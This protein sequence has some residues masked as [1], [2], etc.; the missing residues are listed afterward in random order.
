MRATSKND[1]IK[2]AL[3]SLVYEPYWSGA[4]KMVK[5]IAV[6]LGDKYDITI[7]TLRLDKTFLRRERAGNHQI[8][9]VGFGVGTL[10][11]FL[12]PFLAASQVIKLRPDII[13][14]IM[15]SYA[16]GALVILR[17]LYP[18]GRRILTLQSGDLDDPKKQKRFFIKFFWRAIH[19]APH[20]ITAI[21]NFLSDRAKKMGVKEED[22]LITPNGVDFA[23][24]SAD[25][26]KIPARVIC[27]ARLSWEKGLDYLLKAWPAVS[28]GVPRARLVLVGEGDKRPE[29]EGL[30]KELG[31][32][33]SVELK[34]ALPHEQTLE[35][36]AKSSVFVCPSLAE[37]LGI[38]FIEAQA[39]GVP[40]IGTRVGGIPDVIQNGE[41]GLLIKPK[42]SEEI[43][44]ALIKLLT[45]K[46]LSEKLVRGARES[47][48]KF[49]WANI[50]V[51]I[52]EL[53]MKMAGPPHY[54]KNHHN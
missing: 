3:L 7:I 39:A 16:A 37:G 19:K 49:D 33:E 8:I 38:V 30:I 22:V 21:S 46:E 14:A 44:A 10:N 45:D 20:K 18:R 4:E 5:E 35:E 34:G 48:K 31:L 50:M 41:N 43:S 6:R 12:F 26:E 28:A 2:I 27:V 9:R 17:Y 40:V 36:I 32:A 52:D 13:H 51:L 25:A 11:K 53:Y 24:I 47:V 15:E 29:I 1:K 42:S 54:E 23:K